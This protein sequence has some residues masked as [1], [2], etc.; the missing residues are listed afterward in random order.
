MKKII[1]TIYTF[2]LIVSLYAQNPSHE[3]IDSVISLIKKDKLNE[4]ISRSTTQDTILVNRL[5]YLVVKYKDIGQYDSA[6]HY[7]NQALTLSNSLMV[8]ATMSLGSKAY[9]WA[10]GT[11]VSYNQIGNIFWLQSDYPTALKY[12]FKALK[13]SEELG[14]KNLIA[15][16]IGNIGII[17]NNQDDYPKALTCFFKALKI[18]E[19]IGDKNGIARNLV[20]IGLVY[21]SQAED[22]KKPELKSDGYTK[23]LTHYL[24]ALKLF[25]EL[26][27]KNGIGVT[28]GNI[29]IVYYH[30]NDYSKALEY[31]FKALKIKEESGSKNGIVRNMQNTSIPCSPI[32]SSSS[33]RLTRSCVMTLLI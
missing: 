9:G 29:G 3:K 2:G 28:L 7:A 1:L 32:S 13:I 17:Y 26:V 30:Q 22:Q 11:A 12:Y 19:A 5:H 18:E 10:K 24:Q 23:A 33:R 31:Y 16:N 20:N 6:L 15:K 25:K 14:D 4:S 27:N 8:P 21:Q